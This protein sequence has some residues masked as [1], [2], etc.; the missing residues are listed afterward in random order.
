MSKE[1]EESR[2]HKKMVKELQTDLS[3][4]LKKLRQKDVAYICIVVDPRTKAAMTGHFGPTSVMVTMLTEA[5][6]TVAQGMSDHVQEL[7]RDIKKLKGD[8]YEM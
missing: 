2:A 1:I 8:E 5:T 4:L 6:R 7:R 3:P